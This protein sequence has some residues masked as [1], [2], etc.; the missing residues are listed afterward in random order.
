MYSIFRNRF[1]WIVPVLLVQPEALHS[2]PNDVKQTALYGRIK[3]S[4]DAVPAI[5]THD[6]LRA[7]EEIADRVETTRGRGMTLYS[8]WAHSYLSPEI[9]N[10]GGRWHDYLQDC[11]ETTITAI[12]FWQHLRGLHRVAGEHLWTESP[13]ISQVPA[14]P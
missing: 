13:T 9:A 8:L 6:H 14:L 10:G 7:F 5:D 4:L 2:H 3:T 11:A 12:Y 1:L